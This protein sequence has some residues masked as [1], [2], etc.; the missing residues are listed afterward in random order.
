MKL[1]PKMKVTIK[2]ATMYDDTSKEEAEFEGWTNGE[3]KKDGNNGKRYY[4][5][6]E[7]KIN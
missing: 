7:E 1:E 6:T 5:N 3:I 2:L 4:Q